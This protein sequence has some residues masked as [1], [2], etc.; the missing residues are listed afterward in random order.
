M[1]TGNKLYILYRMYSIPL[2]D[3]V[4][5]LINLNSL[6]SIVWG[7]AKKHFALKLVFTANET[8]EENRPLFYRNKNK[9]KGTNGV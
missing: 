1:H 3:I 5:I 4:F 6:L 8:R 2:I 9:S 7:N